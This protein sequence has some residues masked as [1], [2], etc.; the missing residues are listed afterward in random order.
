MQTLAS[1]CTCD[2]GPAPTTA[3]VRSAMQA[4]CYVD[5][6]DNTFDDA[7][8]TRYAMLIALVHGFDPTQLLCGTGSCVEEGSDLLL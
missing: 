3:F 4:L 7:H 2:I 1:L 8:C 6:H 5:M